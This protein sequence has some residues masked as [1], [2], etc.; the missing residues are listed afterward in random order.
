MF[1]MKAIFYFILS[2][3]NYIKSYKLNNIFFTFYKFNNTFYNYKLNNISLQINN[4][5]INSHFIINKYIFLKINTLQNK[6]IY[7]IKIYK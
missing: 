3:L 5:Q 7:N 4:Q 1:N 6:Y 2:Y